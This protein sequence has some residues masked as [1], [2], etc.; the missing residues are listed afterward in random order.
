[1]SN[2]AKRLGNC[3]LCGD[4]VH[5]DDNYLKSAEGYCHRGCITGTPVSA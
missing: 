1:M 4:R 5:T 3:V 2:V